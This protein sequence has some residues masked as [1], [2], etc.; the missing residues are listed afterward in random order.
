MEDL[1]GIA[2]DEEEGESETPN[3]RCDEDGEE[4]GDDPR[5]EEFNSLSE[6]ETEE[7]PSD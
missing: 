4:E 5:L 6:S 2:L 1:K 7:D 3:L